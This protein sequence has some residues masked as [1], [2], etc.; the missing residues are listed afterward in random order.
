MTVVEHVYDQSLKLW[1]R[2][3]RAELIDTRMAMAPADR[4]RCDAVIEQ[5]LYIQLIESGASVVSLYWPFKGEFNSRELMR[6]LDADGVCV[7][8][9]EVVTARAPL[10]FRPWRPGAPTRRGVYGIP[11]PD[12]TD[13]VRPDAVVAP[14]IGFDEAGYRLGY[15]GGYYDRTLAALHPALIIG[16]GYERCRIETIRPCAHDIPMHRIVTETGV[17]ER[18]ATGAAKH[19][20]EGTAPKDETGVEST[21]TRRRRSR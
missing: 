5:A 21:E 19:A 8:L 3:Q 4:K 17:H 13:E 9:P 11:V 15:G 6:R 10:V 14:L 7:A 16:V 12:T 2:A 18:P 1:R 20:A